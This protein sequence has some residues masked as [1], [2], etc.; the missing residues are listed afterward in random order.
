MREKYGTVSGSTSATGS[1]RCSGI[2]ARSTYSAPSRRPACSSAERTALKV[3]PSFMMIAPSVSA[4]RRASSGSGRVPGR[5][6]STS[7][8]RTSGSATAAVAAAKEGTPGTTSVSKRSDS[9]SCMY[10]Y[11]P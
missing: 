6:V 1:H 8:W 4:R 5:M 11:E 10:M 2:E 9:R 7:V 3:R